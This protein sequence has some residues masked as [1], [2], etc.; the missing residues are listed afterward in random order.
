M[1]DYIY[2]RNDSVSGDKPPDSPRTEFNDNPEYNSESNPRLVPRFE[3]PPVI[4]A[5]QFETIRTQ[6]FTSPR[7]LYSPREARK[8][9][10]PPIYIEQPPISYPKIKYTGQIKANKE[11]LPYRLLRCPCCNRFITCP[12]HPSYYRSN[13]WTRFLVPVYNYFIRL[14]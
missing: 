11:R 8:E 3:W 14:F 12:V 5:E 2:D 1:S 9:N 13:V 6:Q 4:E 7:L 10:P